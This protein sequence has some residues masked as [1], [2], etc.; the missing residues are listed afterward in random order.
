MT[1]NNPNLL[2]LP[3]SLT[4]NEGVHVL[5]P[6]QHIVLQTDPALPLLS[7][8][9]RL[10]Q[11]VREH[12][13]MQWA[14]TATAAGTPAAI[15]ATLQLDPT[16]ST[17]DQGYVLAITP[18]QLTIAARTAAGIFYGVC[19]LIQLIQQYGRNIPCLEITDA[20]DFEVRG[21]ML[22]ISRDKVPTMQTLFDLVDLL[23]SWKI[24]Q[25][26][27]YTEHTFAYR[28]HPDVWADA[29]PMT[30]EEILALDAFCR[31]RYIELVPNQNSFGHM[32]RWLIHERYAD[33]AETHGTFDTPW[34]SSMQGPFS[35]SPIDP[36]SIK[37]VR[38]L[39]DELLPHFSSRMFNV[40]CDETVDVGQGRSRQIVQ[41]QGEGRVYLDY[42]LKV[43]DEVK[44]RGRTMQF[45]GDII[46]QHPELIPELPK[47]VIALEWGY[48]GDHPFATTCPHYGASGL[49]FYVCPGTSSWCSI[50]GRTANALANVRNAAEC[51]RANGAAGYLI[52]DWGDRG[53]WQMLP[54]S[55]LG[56][57]AGAAYAW[58]W[59]TNNDLDVAQAISL[60]AF[61]D[62]TGA[63]GRVAYDLGNV[64][65][66]PGIATHN[67]SALFWILQIPFDQLS[68]RPWPEPRYWRE[69]LAAIDQA[70]QPLNAAHI[71]RPDADLILQEYQF[72]ARLLRHAC[73]RGLLAFDTLEERDELQREL[74]QDMLEII[75]EYERLWLARNRRGGLA[76]S[77]ARLQQAR[78]DYALTTVEAA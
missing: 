19:T 36:G 8:G 65:S 29:S 22:D 64:Y 1:M 10:Q 53:H 59:D 75:R 68:A 35:L 46:V 54:V 67:G 51:G 74:D 27:L 45:W 76:D 17:H 47:D 42:L 69:A 14:I 7:C 31:E 58:A 24:N 44:A 13:G 37:L 50:G 48:E 9:R 73:R 16:S 70:M 23:A 60:H 33:L 71:N 43:Y 39:F 15:G 57:A 61:R 28:N 38:G 5:Q 21:V 18:E 4:L 11:A 30:G 77:V 78:A 56:F 25:F 41:E 66:L 6:G 49:T 40:G 2:P 3:R 20:P 63:M 72:T 62:A 26:Q 12:T 32:H 55:Y 34:G 52:T